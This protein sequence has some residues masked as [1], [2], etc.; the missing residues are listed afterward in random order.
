MSEVCNFHYRYTSTMRDKMR[1]KS[2]KS[3]CGIFKEF[4]CKL[5]WKISIWS[6]TN[7]QDFWLSQTCNFFFKKLFCPPLVTCING[8]CL[9]STYLY[10]RHLSTASNSQT[11]NS[12]MART[13]ELSKD[14]RKKIVDLHQAGKSE[15]TIGKQAF[16]RSFREHQID[17]TAITRHNFIE[18]NAD[19][20]MIPILPLSR[21]IPM[22]YPWDCYIFALAVFLT[23]TNQ[24]HKWSH[25]Y[26]G[27]PYWVTLLQDWH[28]VFPRKHSLIHHVSPHATYYCITTGENRCYPD[29]FW[30]RRE[31]LI[32]LIGQKPRSD[33][34][35]RAKKT[36][37]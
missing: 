10:K 32:R 29:Y 27:L 21:S 8:T 15:S 4:I 26:F 19:N 30:R 22:S 35:S 33:D 2:W 16:I 14:T 3:Q 28:M 20:C 37:R 7:K 36:D 25:S 6:P 18:T 1:K 34:L 31:E 11:P 13:K 24:I 12:T 23:M 9:N 17:P 5:W